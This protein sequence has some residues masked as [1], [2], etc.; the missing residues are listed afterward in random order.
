[1]K[2]T[3]QLLLIITVVLFAACDS[4]N[5]TKD[6]FTILK[7]GL[8]VK[9]NEDKSGPTADSGYISKIHVKYSIG[10]TTLFDSHKAGKGEAVM[11]PISAPKVLG[12]LMEGFKQLSEGDKATFRVSSDS[13]FKAGQPRPPFIDS[14]AMAVWEIEVVELKSP[15]D[16][17]KEKKEIAEKEEKTLEDFAKNNGMASA[18]K[19]AS[20]LRILV[21]KE[22]NGELVG[23]GREATM[24][25][26]GT[27]LDGTKFDS[28]VDPKF[29]HTDPFTFIVGR[30]MV[31]KGWD[32]GVAALKVGSKAKLLIPSA[33]AY[34]PNARPGNELNPTGIPA[35]SPLLFEVEVLSVKDAPKP[36]AQPQLNADGTSKQ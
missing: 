20:G 6:G 21:T 19:T 9:M 26:T 8:Q 33:I 5:K 15:E 17:E 18:K 31:I 11:Q 22:G 14:G 3:I 34:G 24:K 23:S 7:N 2:N 36:P 32:E 13:F 28:N 27:L 35:N 12:D 16:V 29:K 1:M 30:G 4:K 25:Y 10:D